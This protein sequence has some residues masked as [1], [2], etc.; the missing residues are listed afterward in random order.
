MPSNFPKL[1]SILTLFLCSA[2]AALAADVPAEDADAVAVRAAELA[3]V[4]PAEPV[5]LIPPI[6]DRKKLKFYASC[7]D[8][9]HIIKRAKKYLTDPI[10][11]LP[12][13]LHNE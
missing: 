12:E 2:A 10:P 11:E 7:A 3:A 5:R 9:A 13:E 6:T 4:I 1:I 8:S